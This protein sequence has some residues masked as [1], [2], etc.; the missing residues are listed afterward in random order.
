MFHHELE[1]EVE[2]GVGTNDEED[3]QIMM[4]YSDDNGK[5]WSNELWESIGSIGEYKNRARLH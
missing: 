3:P 1:V 5:T 4:R 2:A